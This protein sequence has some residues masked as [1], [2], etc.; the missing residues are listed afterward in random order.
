MSIGYFNHQPSGCFWYRIKNPMDVMNAHGIETRMIN[1]DEDVVID[2][3]THIQV[4]G[5]YPFLFDKVLKEFKSQ[6]KKVV[7][8]LDDA[9][10]LIEPTNPFYY[11]VIRD[12]GSQ[13]EIFK[14]AD[15]ITVATEELAKY[16]RTKTEAPITVIPN[17]YEPNEWRF[18]RPDREG[19]R[20]GF[21]GSSTH[22]E[23]LL[24]V[25]PIIAKLQK[26]YDVKFLLMGF[27]NGT[28]EEWARGFRF[29]SPPEALKVLDE[30]ENIL[31]DMKFEWIP[32]VDFVNYPSTLINMALD[33]GI[34]PLKDNPFNR[35]R[36][37]SKAME[38]TLAGALALASDLPTYS[39]DPTSTLVTDWEKALTHFVE[40]PDDIKKFQQENLKWVKENRNINLRMDLLKSVYGI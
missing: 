23:D 11:S 37:A 3:M 29:S 40:N 16:A 17:C 14:Y 7:Y 12:K 39:Q 31:K 9:L 24:E 22:V 27:G 20:I 30:L 28:Y 15:H 1:L 18:P 26:S 21:A 25:L 35:A 32:F 38:Y 5:I 36:S 6:G 8:D 19:I 10:D 2:D 13:R 4:Y 33:I 34:C